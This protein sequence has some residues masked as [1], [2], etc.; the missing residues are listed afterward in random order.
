MKK[1]LKLQ[2]DTIITMLAFLIPASIMLLI[3][4]MGNFAPFGKVS[5]LVAD[6]QYQFVDYI[7]Y[8]K[9]V[10]Y[11]ND[12]LFYSF[13]KTFGGDMSGFTSYYLNNPF[14]LLLLFVPNNILPEGIVGMMV[15]I[16]GGCG[17]T[18]FLML[19]GVFGKRFFAIGFSTAYAMMGFMMAYINCIHYFF[20]VMLLPLVI[21]G[22]FIMVRERKSSLLYIISSALAIIS[23]YYIG[24]MILIFT[25]AF[26]LCLLFSELV[27]F[28]DMKDRIRT[29]WIVLYSTL[30][31]VGISA[32][33]LCAVVLSLQGQ[34]SSGLHLTLARTFNIF[35]FFA[36]LY[37]GSFNGNISD[38]TPIIYSGVVTVVF[39][40]LYFMNGK[41]RVKEK[42]FSAI[43]LI[44]MILGFWVDAINV[45]WHGF[46]HPIG[47]P[48]RNSF[49]FS[50]L[51]LFFGYRG[52]LFLREGFKKK[53]ANIIVVL[54]GLYS[55]FLYLIHSEY[56]DVEAIAVSSVIVA[57]CLIFIVALTEKN[58]YIVP[59]LA[60]LMILQFVD[61]YHNGIHS[62]NAYYEDKNDESVSLET[63]KTYNEETQ[64]LID[65]IEEY[66]PS[67]YRID[68]TYRRTHNDPM[69]FGYNGLS[70]FSSCETD[71]V[72]RFMGK[73]GFRDNGNWAFYGQGSS[74]F[75]DCFMGVKYLLSQYD[76]IC[77]PYYQIYSQYGKYVY[78]NP[79]ALSLGFGMDNSVKNINMEE[80]DLFKLQNDI[81]SSFTGTKYE[82]YNPVKVSDVILNNVTK[83]GNIYRRNSDEE[84]YIEYILSVTNSNFIY[85]Y[86]DAP[87]VQATKLTVN[88][89][90][91]EDYFN[92]YD[93]SIRECG[94]FLPGEKIPV[95][96]TLEQDEIEI[97]DYQFYYENPTIIKAWFDES[98]KTTC[99]I[100]KIKSSHLI[101]NVNVA[102]NSDLLVLSIPYEK[103]W[104]VTIDGQKVEPLK[105]MDA[106]MG[107]EVTKGNHIIELKYIPRGIIIGLPVTVLCIITT[108]CVFFM[109][110]KKKTQAN[111]NT[112]KN[113]KIY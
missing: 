93:W 51:V 60:G 57:L 83:D 42:I 47:F 40:M 65:Q 101:A 2:K 21:W 20:S 36:G 75:A 77:K 48:F 69:M 102:D 12:D 82:I 111:K 39:L 66:D 16:V 43:L 34:K 92:L 7:G 98:S 104:I 63:Y 59:A 112:Q 73:L 29:S 91:K 99:D 8:L 52:V 71:Q 61:L 87:V 72:K 109:Q 4:I 28:E 3:F 45:A 49:L 50:F 5:I 97:D 105:V 55:I 108:F 85:M 22:L 95:R 35:E 46:A 84:A 25:A 27:E 30:L 58:K 81:A 106:L 32:T 9:Q 64:N 89:M 103:D 110:K 1:F 67:F 113:K 37:S 62:V 80:K 70:H 13:S 100:D 19:Q 88:G 15:L 44:F 90:D 38:G 26:F 41:I 33:S 14:F 23:C 10:F 74:T 68:K 24:Y 76:S 56:A 54:F 107:F 53:H 6:M 94:Y 96:I 11:G 17:L 31:S 86:F 18:F 78:M 79:F